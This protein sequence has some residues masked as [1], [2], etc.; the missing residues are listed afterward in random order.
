MQDGV[1]LRF[2]FLT[3]PTPTEPTLNIT[4]NTQHFRFLQNRDQLLQLNAQTADA[5]LRGA[6]RQWPPADQPSLFDHPA[7]QQAQQLSLDMSSTSR[8][9]GHPTG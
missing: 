4:I 7:D 1:P 8:P 9:N 5:L 6:V 2:V 3:L